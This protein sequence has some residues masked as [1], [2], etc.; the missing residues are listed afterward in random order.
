[1][2]EEAKPVE[3]PKD[4]TT[5]AVLST[6]PITETKAV[7]TTEAPATEAVASTSETPAAETAAPAEEAKKEPEPVEEGHLEHKGPNFPK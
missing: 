4:E 1:M 2:A 5:P 3:V 6:E 7:E